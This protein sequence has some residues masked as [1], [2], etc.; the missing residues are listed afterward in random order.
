MEQLRAT[1]SWGK[2]SRQA[3]LSL[4]FAELSSLSKSHLSSLKV[5]SE[6]YHIM[7]FAERKVTEDN[8]ESV[9]AN[10]RDMGHKSWWT[11]ARCTREGVSGET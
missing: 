5:L 10:F 8:I 6:R 3:G 1:R 9:Q 4:P 2:P 7:G 11:Q